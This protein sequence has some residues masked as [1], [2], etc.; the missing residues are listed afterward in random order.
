MLEQAVLDFDTQSKK[1]RTKLPPLENV[2]ILY[3]NTKYVRGESLKNWP[4]LYPV[5]L[6]GYNRPSGISVALEKNGYWTV[7]AN[8]YCF[9]LQY[10]TKVRDAIAV[11]E[12]LEALPIDW[13]S[14]TYASVSNDNRKVISEAIKA[15]KEW[16]KGK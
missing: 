10:I 3:Q 4:K 1:P 6:Q 14:F 7:I 15:I 16:L 5:T 8:S 11:A 13:T 9:G 12:K 2:I